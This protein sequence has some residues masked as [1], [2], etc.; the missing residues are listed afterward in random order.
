MPQQPVTALYIHFPFCRARCAYCDFNTYAGLDHLVPDYVE[1]LGVEAEHLAALFSGPLATVYVGGGTPS[2]VPASSLAQVLDTC[3]TMF[4]LNPTAEISVE[5]NPGTLT[6]AWLDTL[7]ARGVNRLSLGAQSLNDAELAMLGR[8][9]RRADVEAA[10]AAARA[11]GFD[12]LSLD[13]IFGLP[14][15]RL[16]DWRAMLKSALALTPDHL[17]LYALTLEEGTPLAGRVQRGDLPAPDADRA[18]D[19]YELADELL[20]AQG[21]AQYEISNWCRPGFE[22]V[23]NLTCWRYQP[24][25]ALGAGAHSFDGARRRWNVRSV[26][27]YIKQLSSATIPTTIGTDTWP[28]PAVED[29]EM[30]SRAEQ[31]GETMMLGLRLTREGVAEVGFRDRF[32]V[33]LDAAYPAALPEMVAAGLIRRDGGRVR[34]TRRGRLLGNRVFARFLPEDS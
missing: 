12:N 6:R 34:L 4:G 26:P 1:A 30:L 24:Y 22:C 21:F 32:G 2:L 10:V 13:L 14:G 29:G 28:S 18:A 7:R 31:M 5:A 27:D 8:I 3:C 9:H 20:T 17:S 19:M 15:Q 16:A 33:S 25:L 11:A 23:H